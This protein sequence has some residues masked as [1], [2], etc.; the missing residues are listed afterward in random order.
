MTNNALS[1]YDDLLY[2]KPKEL[3]A[4]YRTARIYPSEDTLIG[5]FVR[6]KYEATEMYQVCKAFDVSEQDYRKIRNRVYAQINPLAQAREGS[7]SITDERL[8]AAWQHINELHYRNLNYGHIIFGTPKPA[9]YA[10]DK[11]SMWQL[12]INKKDLTRDVVAKLLT[13][14]NLYI[15]V[16][17]SKSFSRKTIDIGNINALYL[18]IDNVQDPAAYIAKCVK[19]GRFDKLEPS[20]IT[21]SGGGLHIYFYLDNA[22]A[23]DKLNPYVKRIQK[24]LHEIYPE[25]DKLSDLSRFLRL[26]GSLYD[27][28]NK[29]LKIVESVFESDKVYTVGEI[30]PMLVPAYV[31]KDK[32]KKTKVYSFSK[33]LDGKSKLS[34]VPGTWRDLEVN[35]FRDIEYLASIGHFDAERRKRAVFFYAL[36]VYRATKSFSEAATAAHEF[37]AALNSP[38]SVDVVE[39]QICSIAENGK[40]WSYKRE[41]LVAQLEIDSNNLDNAQIANLQALFPTEEK[42]RRDYEQRKQSRRNKKG[43]TQREQAKKEK[44]FKVKTLLEQGLDSSMIAEELQITKRYINKIIKEIEVESN[45]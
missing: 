20:R 40:V 32:P 36:F 22:Y 2:Y 37:N 5:S 31:S 21:V 15:M 42:R 9:R 4:F 23:N 6:Y 33:M 14:S 38:L 34:S 11:K 7:R 24:A 44:I 19:E 41:T 25:A 17:T 30:G 18:D 43:L 10:G 3:I 13:V 26:E 35:R 27:K 39:N 45:N 12:A 8:D 16:N 28:P 1:N 29:A